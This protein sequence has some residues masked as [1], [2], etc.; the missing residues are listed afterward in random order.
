MSVEMNFQ[1]L[2]C[3]G[4]KYKLTEK[5]SRVYLLKLIARSIRIR[6]NK[7]FLFLLFKKFRSV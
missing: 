3:K 4:N 7:D 5:D 2:H 6:F 1:N